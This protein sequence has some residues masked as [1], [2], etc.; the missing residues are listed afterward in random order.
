MTPLASR[1]QYL[2]DRYLLLYVQS[3]TPDD[4][5][6]RPSETCKV[7]FQNKAPLT[8]TLNS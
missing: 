1:Q 8:N 2:F 4:G 6:E 7:S 3:C 5:Q